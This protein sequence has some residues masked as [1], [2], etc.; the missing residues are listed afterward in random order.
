MTLECVV[1]SVEFRWTV[2]AIDGSPLVYTAVC[3]LEE[4]LD[5]RRTSEQLRRG[6]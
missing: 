4:I 6:T 2:F 5:A 3:T 1:I